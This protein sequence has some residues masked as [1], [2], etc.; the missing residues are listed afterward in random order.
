[1]PNVTQSEMDV[2][3]SL[4]WAEGRDGRWELRDGQPLMMARERGVHALTKFAVQTALNA[5]IQRTGLTL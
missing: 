4:I 3:A 2:D 5:A 1:M